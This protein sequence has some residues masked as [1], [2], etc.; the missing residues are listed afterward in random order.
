MSHEKEPV[1]D[2]AGTGMLLMYA[3]LVGGGVAC[4]LVWGMHQLRVL[5]AG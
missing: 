4:I 3:V 5:A 2:K 1:G